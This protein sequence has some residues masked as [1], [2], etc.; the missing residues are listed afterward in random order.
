MLDLAGQVSNLKNDCNHV[1]FQIR[2]YINENY[3]KKLTLNDLA[4]IFHINHT[5]LSTLFKKETGMNISEYIQLIKI[6]NAKKLLTGSNY[7]I[8]LISE[9]VGFTDYTYFCTIFKKAAGV[10]PLQFRLQSVLIQG[11]KQ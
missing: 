6:E 2:N 9:K 10:S 1:I 4:D 8:Q 7:K 3:S 11:E 5:Y